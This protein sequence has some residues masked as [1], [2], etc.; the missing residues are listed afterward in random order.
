MGVVR[1]GK[2][3]FLLSARDVMGEMTLVVLLE[4][5]FVTF[6]IGK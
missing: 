3:F 4:N 2:Q 1:G 5:I 6:C